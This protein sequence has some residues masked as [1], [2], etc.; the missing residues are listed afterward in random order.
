MISVNT[1]IKML[2]NR[3]AKLEI[4]AVTNVN[5]IR[6]AKRQLRKLSGD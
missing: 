6:K 4:D 3:I 1:K 2:E 5:L